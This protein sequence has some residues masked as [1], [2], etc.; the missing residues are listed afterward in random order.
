VGCSANG[1]RNFLDRFFRKIIK[2]KISLK[3]TTLNYTLPHCVGLEVLCSRTLPDDG[4]PVPKHVGVLTLFMNCILL[5]A[6]VGLCCDCKNM[7]G[8]SNIKYT[9]QDQTP[10]QC[11]SLSFG[12][13]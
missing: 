4:S 8:A 12:T 13:Y 11:A 7:R 3:S 9:T 10:R 6:F 5:S 2:Y 1:S